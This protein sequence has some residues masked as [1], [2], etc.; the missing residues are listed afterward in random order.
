MS[1]HDV[2]GVLG[3]INTLQPVDTDEVLRSL[4]SSFPRAKLEEVLS[5]L[6]GRNMVKRLTNSQCVVTVLGRA[7][8][9]SGPI[10]KQRD[11]A[12]ML[13][14]FERSKGGRERP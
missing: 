12:R 8:L 10:A 5:I 13:H 2:L 4:P 1:S 3:L 9:G 14:L 11:I 6:T 7:V